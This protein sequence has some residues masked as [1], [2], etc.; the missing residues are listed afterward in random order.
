MEPMM[1]PIKKAV[2][3]S[4]AKDPCISLVAFTVLQT[5]YRD[6]SLHSG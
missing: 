3:L 4:N 2:I 5:K 1:C 6:P